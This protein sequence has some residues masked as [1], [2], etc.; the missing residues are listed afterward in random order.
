M[1]YFYLHDFSAPFWHQNDFL[2]IY[3]YYMVL[4]PCINNINRENINSF[5]STTLINKWEFIYVVDIQ[6]SNQSILL[7]ALLYSIEFLYFPHLRL[8]ASQI[9]GVFFVTLNCICLSFMQIHTHFYI[10]YIIY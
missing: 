10:N 4:V 3:S 9:L 2:L 8:N 7:S 6:A 1:A 5:S